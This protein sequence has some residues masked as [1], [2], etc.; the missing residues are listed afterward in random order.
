[1]RPRIVTITFP[2][3]KVHKFQA[4]P[5]PKVQFGFVLVYPRMNFV[6][7]SGTTGTLVPMT[8][9]ELV[10]IGNLPG[11]IDFFDFNALL[12]PTLPTERLIFNPTLFQFTTQDGYSYLIDEKTGLQS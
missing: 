9:D 10:A 6:P 1:I 11:I 8:G 4:T 5:T 7:L 3:G 2:N 12:D